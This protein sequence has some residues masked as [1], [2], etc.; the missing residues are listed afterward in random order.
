METKCGHAGFT[1]VELAI[2][3]VIIG[4]IVGGVLAGQ[5]LIKAATVRSVVSDIERYNAAATTF[6]SKFGGLPGDL[7]KNKAV[8]FN[9][10]GAA[11][12]NATGAAGLRDGNNVIE[13]GSAGATNLIGEI[14]LFWKD[15]G[16]SGLIG[17]SYPGTGTVLTTG[18][19]VNGATIRSYMPTSK[20]RE[21]T[22]HF[23]YSTAGRNYFY[24][25]TVTTNATSAVTTSNSVTP[26]EAKGLDEKMDDGA[27]TTGTVLSM[28]NLTTVDAGTTQTT[29]TCMNGTVSP[30]VYNVSS[31][32]TV[33]A[34]EA[35]VCQIQLRASF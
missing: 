19:N 24:L 23:V 1:L 20:L 30:K 31:S 11:D 13:G 12:T 2:S 25:S 34:L 28:T 7:A 17:G 18:A 5:G 10:S 14:G 3:L 15:L 27:P 21:N 6:R 16:A 9:F 8:E 35:Q 32:T 26:L 4:L 29:G 33:G 22:S